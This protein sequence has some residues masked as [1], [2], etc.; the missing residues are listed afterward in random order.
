[1]D[2]TDENVLHH[3]QLSKPA[4][5]SLR[6]I[7]R[8]LMHDFPGCSIGSLLSVLNP[9]QYQVQEEHALHLM[10]LVVQEPANGGFGSI[11]MEDNMELNTDGAA[12]EGSAVF[13]EMTQQLDWLAQQH[14]SSDAMRAARGN[15]NGNHAVASGA[16]GTDSSAKSGT[17][18][19]YDDDSPGAVRPNLDPTQAG[20]SSPKASPN[21]NM[22]ELDTLRTQV[23]ELQSQLQTVAGHAAET[24]DALQQQCQELQADL[25]ASQQTAQQANVL[26]QDL[27]EQQ[28]KL[29]AASDAAKRER[30]LTEQVLTLQAEVSELQQTADTQ[31][32]EDQSALLRSDLAASQQ[33]ATSLQHRLDAA[34]AEVQALR[35][36]TTEMQSAAAESEQHERRNGSLQEQL[37]AASGQIEAARL[38]TDKVE[39]ERRTGADLGSELSEAQQEIERLQQLLAGQQ[40]GLSS[41]QPSESGQSLDPSGS[42]LLA[43]SDLVEAADAAIQVQWI[44]L[45]RAFDTATS[46]CKDQ[47]LQDRGGVC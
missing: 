17:N 43:Q 26:K 25:A 29:D 23:A 38:I 32:A 34:Q 27:K 46:R 30:E 22:V 5:L 6:F 14:I 13:Q 45:T 35:Q 44:L 41:R 7:K 24:H 3:V 47:I 1:M 36:Q 40:A 28:A 8:H 19:Q 11:I 31:G 16:A 20:T 2:C 21:A 12:A 37:T 39:S 4:A 33:Q 15:G 42:M 10:H 18:Q 9:L